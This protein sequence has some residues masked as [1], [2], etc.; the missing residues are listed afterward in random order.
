VIGRAAGTGAGALVAEMMSVGEECLFTE[1]RRIVR[2]GILALT[3]VR[4]DHLDAMGPCKEDIARTFS[5][6]FPE[7]AAVFFP[8][9]ESYPAFT[10]AA[11]RLG[12]RLEPVE[13]KITGDT[14]LPFEEFEANVRLALAVLESLGVDRGRALR[15]M[16]RSLPDF[17]SLRIWKAE[18]GAPLRPAF[19]ASA[20]AANDP[21]SSA[22]ALDRI[23]NMLPPGPRPLIGLLC[24]REDRGDRTL[25][26]IR[27]AAD[28]FFADF[29]RIAVLGRPARAA[30]RQLRRVLGPGILKFSS[31]PEPRPEDLMN[32]IVRPA[33][34]EPVI[35]GF[36]NIVG[37]GEKL[38]Q[39]W[40]KVG[41]PHGR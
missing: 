15:G 10:A 23:M 34:R 17:G 37:P 11:A 12:S 2:P 40:E 13:E 3:N 41:T 5:A 14:G 6:A 8:K 29:E 4:L 30:A 18:F 28:G 33:D 31:F 27:A 22:A 24:L 35:I 7:N 20:F 36:G 32:E 19:C 9:E 38:I 21:E 26:W 1:S 25:Q 39:Y 16:G